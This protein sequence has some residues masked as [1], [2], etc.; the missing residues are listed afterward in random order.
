MIALMLCH[1]KLWH[2]LLNYLK[3]KRRKFAG[4]IVPANFK[5]H[6]DR[7]NPLGT[8]SAVTLL[9]VNFECSHHSYDSIMPFF[10]KKMWK[11]YFCC[12][13]DLSRDRFYL[14]YEHVEGLKKTWIPL[15]I[16]RIYH[17]NMVKLFLGHFLYEICLKNQLKKPNFT[18]VAYRHQ[19][20]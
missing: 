2:P 18:C 16:C 14:G 20:S 8:R 6:P 4:K 1:A 15:K 19:S 3:S 9:W 10:K 5:T 11:F 17:L 13:N 7:F 12:Y